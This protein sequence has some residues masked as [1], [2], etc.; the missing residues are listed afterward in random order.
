M[1]W[2]LH[3]AGAPPLAR[4]GQAVGLA[5]AA[6][7]GTAHAGVGAAAP[8]A[9]AGPSAAAAGAHAP[10]NAMQVAQARARFARHHGVPIVDVSEGEVR[11][12]A[13]GIWAWCQAVASAPAGA[14]AAAVPAA[15]APPAGASPAELAAHWAAVAELQRMPAGA[16]PDALAGLLQPGL[17]D[18]SAAGG[19][20]PGARGAASM[21]MLRRDLNARP[22]AWSA[23]IRGNAE[24]ALAGTSDDPDPRVRS[25]VEFVVRTGTI[26]KGNRTAAYLGYG[27]ARVADL[28]ARGQHAMAE[29]LVLLLLT[30]LEQAQRDNGRW[31]LAWL[32][33]H[34]PEPPWAQMA[35]GTSGSVDSLR[36]F[37]HLA[38]TT[39]TTAAMAYTK[40]AASLAEIR[41]KFNDDRGG[42]K[43]EEEQRPPRVPPKGGRGGGG[44]GD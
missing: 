39:W 3:A 34:M 35:A 19:K 32:L 38:D 20:M 6:P 18:G 44:K 37:G 40:D 22:T 4:F 7:V 30:A 15:A 16:A 31:Q 23:I 17:D 26:S 11:R 27:I 33:T 41:K 43:T 36:P 21:E 42:G 28:Q 2:A 5:G 29:A 8:P 12:S 10:L 13:E 1:E 24:Q 25:L 9:V 14:R